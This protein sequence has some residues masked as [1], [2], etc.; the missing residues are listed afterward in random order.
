MLIKSY[1]KINLVLNVTG[2]REDGMHTLDMVMLP[3]ELH[4]SLLFSN[5]KGRKDSFVTFEDF[6]IGGVDNNLVT[7]ALHILENEAKLDTTYRVLINKCIPIS[8]GLGGGS[9]NC[10]ATL[11]GVNKAANL[12]L[13]DEKLAEMGLKLGSDVPFFI[14]SVPARVSGIGDVVEP[15][16]IKN[17]YWVL[18]IKPKE[19]LSTEEIYKACD[20]FE[21]KTYDVDAVI[22]ALKEGDDDL[23]AANIG[24]SLEDVSVSKL[25]K[26]KIIKDE[27]K[28]YG[29]K[30]AMMSGSGSCVFAM[31]TDK[32]FAKKAFSH[33][34]KI[35]TDCEVEITRVRKGGNK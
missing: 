26:V 9:S 24:N 15:I 19:G 8:A 12:G 1:A 25:P 11:T 35:K 28:D 4:D 21:L 33:F 7:R 22:K 29:F 17:D 18:L 23:L 27:L 32:K 6:S 10:A 13:S 16:E 30:I 3:L 14:K 34:F 31:T 2:K 5:L 20:N